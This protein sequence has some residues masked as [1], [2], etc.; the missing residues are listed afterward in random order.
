[1]VHGELPM[2]PLHSKGRPGLRMLAQVPPFGWRAVD[3]HPG[4]APIAPRVSVQI[5]SDTV[6][7]KNDHVQAT[8]TRSAAR[9]LLTSLQVDGV[10]AI[11]APSFTVTEYA[12]QGGLWRLGHEM[13]N[14]HFNA[15]AAGGSDTVKLLEASP[16][17]ARV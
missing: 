9:F 8:F 3:L 13:A 7:L 6:V 5:T 1:P 11:A 17:T 2:E 4:A 12:D 14:C 16:L 15:N 10:E